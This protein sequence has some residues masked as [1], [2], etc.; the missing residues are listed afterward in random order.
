[1]KTGLVA[2]ALSTAAFAVGVHLA[3]IDRLPSFIMSRTFNGLQDAGLTWNTWTVAPRISPRTQTIVRSSPDL[4]YAVCMLD[5]SHGPV[6]ITAPM[7][8]DYGSM[9]V[10]DDDTTN[11]YIIDLQGTGT[12]VDVIVATQSQDVSGI[13]ADISIVRLRSD[14]G[15]ALIRRLA[16]D[17]EL[18]ETAAALV[19]QAH[20]TNL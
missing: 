3:V 10:F 12:P 7:G 2:F 5:L 13:A 6:H 16:P 17:T 19:S 1:M 8:P 18:H 15:L 20:C 4:A 14:R 11:V 9:S